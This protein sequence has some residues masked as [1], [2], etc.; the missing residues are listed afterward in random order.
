MKKVKCKR[1]SEEKKHEQKQKSLKST[2]S[3]DF[4]NKREEKIEKGK[5][6]VKW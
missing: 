3:R 6:I 2:A 5:D 4:A 1:Q